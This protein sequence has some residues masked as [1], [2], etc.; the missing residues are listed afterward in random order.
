MNIFIVFNL[1]F[2]VFEFLNNPKRIFETLGL[3]MLLYIGRNK[4]AT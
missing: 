2:T 4:Y 3:H 1:F